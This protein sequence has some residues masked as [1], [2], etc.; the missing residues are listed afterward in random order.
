ML[1]AR[2]RRH[3]QDPS[4]YESR[5]YRTRDRTIPFRLF[6]IYAER[7]PANLAYERLSDA[8]AIGSALSLAFSKS[9]QLP[10]SIQKD[11]R[12]AFIADR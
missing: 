10:D 11:Q 9:A 6:W 5:R 3:Y 8:R 1:L 2:F 7:I 12:D 4:L